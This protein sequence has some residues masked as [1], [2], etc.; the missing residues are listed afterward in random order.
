MVVISFDTLVESVNILCKEMNKDILHY[1]NILVGFD[2]EGS[3]NAT[4]EVSLT[5]GMC[6][7]FKK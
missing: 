4:G 5:A 7:I 6:I 3:R 2:Q 1:L